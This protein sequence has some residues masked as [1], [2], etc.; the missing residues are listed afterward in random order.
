MNYVIHDLLQL[1][2][3]F[4][5]SAIP[6]PVDQAPSFGIN[7]MRQGT[8]ILK[9]DTIIWEMELPIVQIF[10]DCL[11]LLVYLRCFNH[12]FPVL[13]KYGCFRDET[14]VFVFV[15]YNRNIPNL[16]FFE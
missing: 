11:L 13:V 4:G 7:V 5:V 9:N 16:V 8:G 12:S 3:R 15:F 2:I 14:N 6:I 10:T 1:A